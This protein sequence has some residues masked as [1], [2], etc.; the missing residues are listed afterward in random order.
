MSVWHMQ[1][2][3]AA[4]RRQHK[5]LYQVQGRYLRYVGLVA[6]ACVLYYVWFFLQFG[7]SGEQLTTGLQ[8]IGRYLARMFVWHDFWNWPF[9]YYFTQIGITLAIVF[10]GTL[11]ATVLA[12]LLCAGWNNTAYYPSVADLQSSLTIASIPAKPVESEPASR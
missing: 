2:D 1:P 10:A 6:L 5:Q 3:I 4:S 9:G 8:Q 11:T 12:L 7:I